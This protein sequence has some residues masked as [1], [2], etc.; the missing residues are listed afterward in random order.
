MKKTFNNTMTVYNKNDL[1][2]WLEFFE[3]DDSIEN[4][5]KVNESDYSGICVTFNWNYVSR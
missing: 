2:F 4:Y 3:N 1:E 5:E